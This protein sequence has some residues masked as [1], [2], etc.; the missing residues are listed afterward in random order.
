MDC[1]TIQRESGPGKSLVCCIPDS[2]GWS[3]MVDVNLP[4]I[5]IYMMI[6][7]MENHHRFLDHVLIVRFIHSG[8]GVK[9]GLFHKCPDCCLREDCTESG[10]CP[11]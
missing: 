8:E 11:D 4:K 9:Y 3:M 1:R 2:P 7:V 5:Y 6:N 10:G